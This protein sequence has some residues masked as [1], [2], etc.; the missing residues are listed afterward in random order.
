DWFGARARLTGFQMGY[1]VWWVW[2]VLPFRQSTAIIWPLAKVGPVGHHIECIAIGREH[3][4]GRINSGWDGES[5]TVQRFRAEGRNNRFWEYGVN[6]GVRGVQLGQN[7]SGGGAISIH[8][9]I[10][11]HHFRCTLTTNQRHQASS[12][13]SA[14]WALFVRFGKPPWTRCERS[15]PPTA[16]CP[17]GTPERVRY[18]ISTCTPPFTIDW[19]PASI[20]RSL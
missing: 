2:S 13:L 10:T 11:E 16:L 8:P 6:R 4:H 12:S 20:A 1:F 5:L 7:D 15:S 14:C 17:H 19:R 3:Q 9:A 18:G